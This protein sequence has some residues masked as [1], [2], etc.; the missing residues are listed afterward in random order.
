MT[1]RLRWLRRRLRR[2]LALVAAAAAPPQQAAAAAHA[3]RHTTREPRTPSA[4][5][6]AATTRHARSVT[7]SPC[8]F[9]HTHTHTNTLTHTTH[10]SRGCETHAGR[11]ECVGRCRALATVIRRGKTQRDR[12]C[13]LWRSERSNSTPPP[14]TH[15]HR[16]RTHTHM[17]THTLYTVDARTCSTFAFRRPRRESTPPLSYSALTDDD[18]KFT[19]MAWTTCQSRSDSAPPPHHHHHYHHHHCHRHPAPARTPPHPL[20]HPRTRSPTTARAH[21]RVRVRVRRRA[22]K[23][24]AVAHAKAHHLPARE[25]QQLWPRGRRQPRR[26]RAH[27]LPRD[28]PP[29]V[30]R[31]EELARQPGERRLVRRVRRHHEPLVE[32]LCGHGHV[33]PWHRARDVRHHGWR[34]Q[35][36][37]GGGGGRARGTATAAH[38]ARAARRRPRREARRDMRHPRAA[39]RVVAKR[40]PR[41]RVEQHGVTPPRCR[42]AAP[43]TVG[44]HAGERSARPAALAA[45]EHV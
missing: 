35:C 10:Q 30:R 34:R 3:A 19:T 13:A 4:P 14:N 45:V 15:T 38:D 32:A 12:L 43:T 16:R 42:R 11:V 18:T 2:D 22:H 7:R 1:R 6:R 27:G 40:V 36:R 17:C 33:R 41:H 20:A 5:P 28:L 44:A 26:A 29:A 21:R 23:A 25:Q 39:P 24:D 9:M 31:Y 37:G 8:T